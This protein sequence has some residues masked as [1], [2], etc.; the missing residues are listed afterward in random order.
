MKKFLFIMLVLGIISSG[1]FAGGND[2]KDNDQRQDDDPFVALVTDIG[3]ID[4]KSFNQGVWEGVTRFKQEYKIGGITFLQSE[5][6]ADYIPNLS[7]ISDEGYAL[8]IAPGFLFVDAI[9][10]V[11]NN[12]PHTHFLA[13]DMA[14][15][16]RANVASAIFS[17]EQGSFLVGI[18]AALQ[19]KKEN[20]NK[21]AFIGGMDF[22]VIQ[23]FESGFER[24]VEVIDPTIE[25]LIEYAGSFADT[26]KGQ[27]LAAKLFD[28]GAGIIFVAAGSTGNGVIKEAKDRVLQ[29]KTVWVIGVDKD[30]YQDGIYEGT[31]SVIL[32][33]MMKRVDVVAYE[34]SKRELNGEFP[35]GSVIKFD[36]AN[37]GVGIPAE[38]P[39][40]TDK[41]VE[42]IESYTKQVID[43]TLTVPV[44][45]KRVQ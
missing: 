34:I 21:V 12:Y 36:L 33:S 23:H 44:L 31:K 19:A 22:D 10:E 24:G 30:Q 28:Q 3:G 4:D 8:I 38:N 15:E 35:G 14:V 26:Q 16:D 39:N 25:I 32:T 5:S 1:A 37:K 45:P 11:S 20:F 9:S 42:T 13:I 27:T 41:I 6:D 7:T 40:L 18:A 2:E 17:E 29:G 43:G